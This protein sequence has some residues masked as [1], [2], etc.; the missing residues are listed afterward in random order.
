MNKTATVYVALLEEGTQ[1]WRPVSALSLGGNRFGLLGPVPDDE[2]REYQ[3]GDIVLA[4]RRIFADAKGELVAVA[5]ANRD[6]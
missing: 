4:E 3:P 2:I 5:H 1:V 6:V